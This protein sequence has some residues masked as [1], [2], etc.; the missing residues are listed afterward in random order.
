[1][2]HHT[3]P[4]WHIFKPK[5]KM[6]YGWEE[7]VYGIGVFI[8]QTAALLALKPGTLRQNFHMMSQQ[9]APCAAQ[10]PGSAHCLHSGEWVAQSP[11]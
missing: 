6:N 3:Q 2:I 1:M 9:K 7:G 10:T 4:C 5:S 8:H 11:L